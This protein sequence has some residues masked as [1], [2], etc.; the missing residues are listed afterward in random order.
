MTSPLRSRGLS[1]GEVGGVA[2]MN[3]PPIL[4]S[5]PFPRL[6]PEGMAK[7]APKSSP[8][9]EANSGWSWVSGLLL[10]G[11]RGSF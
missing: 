11:S 5:Y 1:P 6:S 7:W 9:G 4:K 3:C 10:S 2:Q 8:L